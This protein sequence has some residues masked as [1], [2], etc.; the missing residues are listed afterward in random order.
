MR[1]EEDCDPTLSRREEGRVVYPTETPME[2]RHPKKWFQFTLA[3]LVWIL[4]LVAILLATFLRISPDEAA[5]QHCIQAGW[6]DDD[7]YWTSKKGPHVWPILRTAE[8]EYAVPTEKLKLSVELR[9]SIGILPWKVV[10][11]QKLPI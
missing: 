9:Q 11:F 10:R 4:T 5:R 7:F 2:D 3:N 8:I 1:Q 6:Q